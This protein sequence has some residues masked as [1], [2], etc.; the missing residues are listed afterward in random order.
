MIKVLSRTITTVERGPSNTLPSELTKIT[1]SAP[2]FAAYRSAAMLVAYDNVFAPSSCQG[3]RAERSTEKPRSRVITDNPDSRTCLTRSATGPTITKAVGLSPLSRPRV[4]TRRRAPSFSVPHS[5]AAI[6]IA[7]TPII[8]NRSGQ[9]ECPCAQNQSTQVSLDHPGAAV[10][11]QQRL[12]DSVAAHHRQVV[13]VQKRC[14]SIEHLMV[15]SHQYAI[16]HA[17]NPND[18]PS[19]RGR[20]VTAIPPTLLDW[21]RGRQRSC[22][23]QP[24]SDFPRRGHRTGR[25]GPT[26]VS[27]GTTAIPSANSEPRSAQQWWSTAVTDS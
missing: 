7:R 25:F 15:E 3:A 11:Y 18:P 10:A 5:S 19:R 6:S 4:R 12:E 22:A 21:S 13:G 20:P 9:A 14:V 16:R 24:T 8:E 17:I 1:S 2:K 27:R 26:S 23:Q